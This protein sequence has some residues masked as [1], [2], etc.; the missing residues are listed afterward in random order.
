MT[1]QSDPTKSS[2]DANVKPSIPVSPQMSKFLKD[3]DI[4]P[5]WSP[6]TQHESNTSSLSQFA[7][8]AKEFVPSRFSSEETYNTKGL[9]STA[10]EWVPSKSTIAEYTV[11]NNSM[12]ANTSSNDELVEVLLLLIDP[13]IL[14]IG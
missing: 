1:S 3:P 2:S 8:S 6:A 12:E 10:N 14:I 4:I 7:V 13:I 9:N 5:Y 11:D